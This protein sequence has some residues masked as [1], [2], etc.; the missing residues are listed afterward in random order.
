MLLRVVA[1]GVTVAVTIV[2]WR[3]VIQSELAD[4]GGVTLDPAKSSVSFTKDGAPVAGPLKYLDEF[5][6][7]DASQNPTSA[8]DSDVIFVGHGVV[9]PEYRWDDYKGVDVKG[10][11]L[12][13]LV[14]DPPVPDPTADRTPPGNRSA[15]E[16]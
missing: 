1:G 3:G 12:V 2:D 16:R 15:R 9:A 4:A 13:M 11:T 7:S 6:G 10:K 8:L 5:V 14:N